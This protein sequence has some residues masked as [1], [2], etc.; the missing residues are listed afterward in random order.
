MRYPDGNEDAMPDKDTIAADLIRWHFQIE[1]GLIAVY[2]VINP[3]EDD[4]AEPNKLL[5]VNTH[6]VSTG[7]FDA[8]GFAATKEV[9]YP[10]LIAEVTPAEL[11]GLRRAGRIPVGWDIENATYFARPAA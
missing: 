9:P 6:T 8:F 3:N 10:T 7:S 5:E 2:R 11:D 4:P 1:P